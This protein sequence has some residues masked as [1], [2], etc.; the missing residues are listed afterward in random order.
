MSKRFGLGLRIP[1]DL[2]DLDS[3]YPEHDQKT[4]FKEMVDV[5]DSQDLL[6]VPNYVLAF[7]VLVI[8]L[9]NILPLELLFATFVSSTVC[10]LCIMYCTKITPYR[11]REQ[12][13]KKI[14]LDRPPN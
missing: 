7:E 11:N 8:S 10:Y 5:P 1:D 13:G 12:V 6:L 3:T 2:P 9:L 4:F 14:I